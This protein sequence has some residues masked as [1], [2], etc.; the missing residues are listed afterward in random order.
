MTDLNELPGASHTKKRS[1]GNGAAHTGSVEDILGILIANQDAMSKTLSSLGQIPKS[2]PE[3]SPSEVSA[4]KA[5]L[6]RGLTVGSVAAWVGTAVG[7]LF[8]AGVAWTM[9]MGANATD[10]EVQDAT[11]ASIIEH[12]DGVDPKSP[13]P[14]SGKPRGNHPDMRKSI[15]TNG[16]ATSP[17]DSQPAIRKCSRR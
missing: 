3:E 1:N 12:N 11:Q 7:V 16:C 5:K 8:S 2:T 10:R 6:K 17:M 14:V 4:I 15:K 13:D 9:F